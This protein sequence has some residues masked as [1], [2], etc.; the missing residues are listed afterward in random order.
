MA[1]VRTDLLEW[2]YATL[3]WPGQET[4]GDR[5]AVVPLGNRVLVAGVDGLGHGDEAA[6]AAGLAV[7]ALEEYTGSETMVSLV[8]RCHAELSGSRGAVMSVALFDAGERTMSWLSVG[9]VEGRLLRKIPT[10]KRRHQNLLLRPG[11]LGHRLPTLQATTF[12]IARGDMVILAT[13]GINPR[14]AENIGSGDPVASIA[15][16]VIES[17]GKGADDALVLVTRYNG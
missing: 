6:R 10:G 1:A 13:D 11:V 8:E 7:A 16:E 12:P 3:T 2:A 14:F 15:N 4:C 5:H 17:H 9:N